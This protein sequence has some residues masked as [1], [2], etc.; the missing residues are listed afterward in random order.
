M[1]YY[2]DKNLTPLK[3]NQFSD[4][5]CYGKNW[6]AFIYDENVKY[7]TNI[8]EGSKVYTLRVSPE[9]DSKYERLLDFVCYEV[10]YNRNVII[11]ASD[12]EKICIRKIVDGIKLNT[13][14][15][16]RENDPKW[17]IMCYCCRY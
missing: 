6:S 2:A 7:Y 16:L 9:I 5:G 13:L 10:G 14:A 17:V 4:D 8:F 11:K 12:A 3:E 15:K 1:I